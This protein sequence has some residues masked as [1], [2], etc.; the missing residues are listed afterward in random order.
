MIVKPAIQPTRIDPCR[1]V[2]QPITVTV[3]PST[4][5]NGTYIAGTNGNDF[6]HFRITANCL[7]TISELEASV[8]YPSGSSYSSSNPPASNYHFYDGATLL[9]SDP[10]AKIKNLNGFF[11]LAT[12][13][14]KVI[15]EN[16]L[17]IL[18]SAT[19][20]TQLAP[21]VNSG[22]ASWFK[23]KAGGAKIFLSGGTDNAPY[24]NDFSVNNVIKTTDGINYTQVTASAGW[25][26]RSNHG[27]LYFDG[28]IWVFGGRNRL[29]DGNNGI[30][31]N[32]IYYNDVWSS[33]DGINWTLET[34]HA[35]WSERVIAGTVVYNNKMWIIG[36]GSFDAAA[37]N[38]GGLGYVDN[39]DVWS[40]VNGVNWTLET[41]N[42]PFDTRYFTQT[43]TVFN[44]QMWVLLPNGIWNST[45]GD[46]WNLVRSSLPQIPN[47]I[48]GL[49]RH[50]YNVLAFNGK[51]WILGGS[52]EVGYY[53]Y[54]SVWSSPDGVNWTNDLNWPISN[55][56]LWEGKSAHSSV[57][58][59]NRMW[60]FGGNSQSNSAWTS[61]D[62]INW[63][64]ATSTI[65][66]LSYYWHAAVSI[67]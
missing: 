17:R 14:S 51:L 25:A 41:N 33:I 1:F 5:P 57:V 53:I 18:L 20:N 60:M 38:A 65:P 28:K 67:P 4:P 34:A 11:S 16:A 49:A 7:V 12:G 6:G 40:S 42:L 52:S 47:G 48:V 21:W 8:N 27:M 15:T 32:N 2:T 46:N 50:T 19:L 56:L 44:N 61:S 31:A 24:P 26:N 54:D 23:I 35:S 39:R 62:G 64:Q 3:D 10:T 55:P 66:N 37:Y 22:Y 36:G 63:I 30:A 45:N 29:L 43:A 59:N 9:G 58:F 13:Q